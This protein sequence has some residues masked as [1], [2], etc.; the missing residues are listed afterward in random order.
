MDGVWSLRFRFE[1]FEAV[2]AVAPQPV[3]EASSGDLGCAAYLVDRNPLPCQ[4]EDWVVNVSSG[5]VEMNSIEFHLSI[6]TLLPGWVT[7][8]MA[9]LYGP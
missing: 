8:V 4:S 9:A 2:L 3:V 6:G 7:V 1:S 5:T